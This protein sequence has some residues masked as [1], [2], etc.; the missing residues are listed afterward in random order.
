[1]NIQRVRDE[2]EFLTEVIVDDLDYL[3]FKLLEEGARKKKE[4]ELQNKFNLK[5]E[6]SRKVEVVID[7][8]YLAN[9]FNGGD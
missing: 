1:M 6:E 4:E 5:Q 2:L 8:D 3:M 9:W 7:D